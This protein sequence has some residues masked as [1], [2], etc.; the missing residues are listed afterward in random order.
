MQKMEQGGLAFTLDCHWQQGDIQ[1]GTGPLCLP[2]LKSNKQSFKRKIPRSE[3]P[4]FQ[5]VNCE[6]S[7]IDSLVYGCPLRTPGI[8]SQSM[9]WWQPSLRM[10]CAAGVGPEL[11]T[12]KYQGK[13][14]NFASTL[15]SFNTVWLLSQ[16][17]IQ[18]LLLEIQW[19]KIWN[20][21]NLGKHVLNMKNLKA[22]CQNP[23]CMHKVSNLLSWLR[24]LRYPDSLEHQKV[25]KKVLCSLKSLTSF[26]FYAVEVSLCLFSL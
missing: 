4:K 20:G 25:C 2:F 17:K 24:W 26:S 23:S 22:H 12:H 14:P 9:C 1:Q 6:T 5:D 10:G 21:D 15:Y 3:V 19:N 11:P 7:L 8:L 13:F 16:K 18:N